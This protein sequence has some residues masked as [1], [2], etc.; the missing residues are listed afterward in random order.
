MRYGIL[1]VT[2]LSLVMLSSG[3]MAKEKAK[4]EH[5]AMDPQAMMEQ[6][7]KA[8]T[9][10]EPHK[11]LATLVGSWTTH[12]KDWMEPGKPPM[13]SDGTVEMTMLLDGR[14]LR[15]DFHGD[16]MGQPYH[17]IGTTGYDNLTKRYE[18]V[19]LD[20]MGTGMFHMAGT[21]SADGKTI[22]MKGT[23]PEPDGSV[24]MHRAVWKI[25]DANNQIF[26]MYGTHKAGKGKSPEMKMMEIV[27]T[28]KP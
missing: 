17:G 18:T 23:H 22:T 14:F 24:M 7:K 19:W 4:H 27:Y 16:M 11:L 1:T 28:R 15:Q 6:Y 26:E 21:A 2:V 25:I 9:P 8:A 5:K 3:A 10:G 13:E 20:T 12:N